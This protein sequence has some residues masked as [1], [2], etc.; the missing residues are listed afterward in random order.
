[1]L[2]HVL[3]LGLV[4]LRALRRLAQQ[5]AAALGGQVAACHMQKAAEH[6]VHMK[7]ALTALP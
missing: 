5:Q 3:E 2:A 7:K 1:M 6:L 4:L